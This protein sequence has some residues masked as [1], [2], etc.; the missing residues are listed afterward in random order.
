MIV[1]TKAFRRSLISALY[2]DIF[3]DSVAEASIEPNWQVIVHEF[4]TPEETPQLVQVKEMYDFYQENRNQLLE[5]VKKHLVSWEKTY[6]L[7]KACFVGLV[8]EITQL[9]NSDRPVPS[10][11]VN[12]YIRLAEEFAGGENPG[13]MHAVGTKIM[14]ELIPEAQKTAL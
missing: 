9:Q 10:N 5:I 12:K 3:S 8:I 11:L 14:E 6:D 1:W 4:S 2:V 7:T 13:L